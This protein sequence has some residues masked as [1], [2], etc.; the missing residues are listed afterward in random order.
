MIVSQGVKLI[1]DT[2][3][4]KEYKTGVPLNRRGE[5]EE[6]FF[7]EFEKQLNID[8]LVVVQLGDLF[9]SFVVGLDVINR[10]YVTIKKAAGY[11]RDKTFIFLQ[12]NHDCSRDSS[13]T[14]AFYILSVLCNGLK[15][16]IFVLDEPYNFRNLFITSWSY[17]KTVKELVN[18]VE[19]DK[20]ILGHFEEPCDPYLLSLPNKIYSGHIH[21][22]HKTGNID[23]VGSILPIAHGEESDDSLF[24]TLELNELMKRSPETLKNK[25]LRVLLKE[26]ETLPIGID[27]LQMIAK[28]EEKEHSTNIKIELNL[29]SLNIE[30]L[31]NEC[32]KDCSLTLRESLYEEYLRLKESK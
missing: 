1:G 27:C 13:R 12:G 31:F 21:K 32:L 10:V 28:R 22:K 11:A 19:Y 14:S 4:G 17:S 7:R 6:L 9:D 24:E 3:L 20:I 25:C 8:S 30:D 16:V 15:N 2:H 23:F 5:R 26:G 18:N 29:D